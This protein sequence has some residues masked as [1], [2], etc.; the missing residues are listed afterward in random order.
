[1]AKLQLAF[2]ASTARVYPY[3]VLTLALF[4]ASAGLIMIRLSQEEGMP[5]LT[6]V[7]IRFVMATIL[8]TPLAIRNHQP[9]LNSLQR[10]DWLM[11]FAAG[12]FFAGDIIMIAEAVNHTSILIAAVIG[13]LLPL[14]TAILE[15]LLLKAPIHR[16]VYVGMVLAILGGIVITVAGANGPV[17]IGE[18]PMLGG[19]LAF[20]SGLSAAAYLTLARSLRQRLQL[21]PYIWLVFGAAGLVA[22]LATLLTGTSL[23]GQTMK[24]Y[25]WALLIVIISQMGAHVGFNIAIAYLSP[26]FIS[27]AAQLIT[28]IV[29]VLAI[30]LFQEVPGPGEVVGSAI[31][32]AGVIF[33]IRGQSQIGTP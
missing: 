32:I 12:V 26:T 2:P 4:A 1:M 33:A 6:L 25:F 14:W 5:T 16:L 8:L 31:I 23:V 22:L 28:I 19:L 3:V 24:G 9:T 21:V 10:R 27:I 7:V 11:L 17:D 30:I 29:A 15:R 20:T 18:N 13:G